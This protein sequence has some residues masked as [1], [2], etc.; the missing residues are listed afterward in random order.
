ME[1][2]G[3]SPT[4]LSSLASKTL[5]S[6]FPPACIGCR[7]SGFWCC[8]DCFQSID[9]RVEAPAIEGIDRVDIV[10]SYANPVLRRLLTSYKYRSAT[11]LEPILKLLLI[12]W[13]EEKNWTNVEGDWIII[14]TPTDEKHI[15]ERGFDHTEHLAEIV[16]QVLIPNAKV[17]KAFRRNRRTEANANLHDPNM[18]KGNLRGSIELVEPVQGN[19]LLVDDVV[20]SGATMGECAKVLRHAGVE[21]V[22]GIAFALGG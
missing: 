20:T 9:F 4:W 15:L 1:T 14:P 16:R 6:L 3:L 22:E 13:M 10:G 8:Q 5:D 7:A 19:I 12:R 21:R 18:R 17:V 2:L 11:C